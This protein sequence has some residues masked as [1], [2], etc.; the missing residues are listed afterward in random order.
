MQ[1]T[2]LSNIKED[3]Y[4]QIEFLFNVFLSIFTKDIVIFS[5]ILPLDF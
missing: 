2:L 3:I 4:G 5:Q 1:I